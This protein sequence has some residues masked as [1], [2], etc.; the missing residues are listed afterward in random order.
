MNAQSKNVWIT[1]AS[2]GIGE[3]LAVAWARRGVRLILSA[4]NADELERVRAQCADAERHLVV[5]LD[6]TKEDEIRQAAERV[7]GEVGAVDVVVHNA[8]I[9]QRSRVAD[10]DLEV[11]R[12]LMEVNYFGAVA[13]TKA[14]LPSMLEAKNG[15]FVVVSSLAGIFSTPLRSGYSAA[16]HALHGFFD[17]LRAEVWRDNIGVTLVCPGFVRTNI[18]FNA[19][20]GDGSRQDRQDEAIEAGRDPAEVAEGIITAVEKGRDQVLIAGK[21]K[22]AVYLKRFTPGLFNRLIRKAKVT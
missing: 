8:G 3:A 15:R 2:S 13:L 14:V 9:T 4:R 12:R 21:E 11:Y 19:L 16:K 10:T 17:G 18:S 20:K 22:G 1:G 6:L 5:P 7:L